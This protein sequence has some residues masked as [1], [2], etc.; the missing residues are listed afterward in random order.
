[1][2]K[3]DN[4][5]LANRSVGIISTALWCFNI[6]LVF[7]RQHT[8]TDRVISIEANVEVFEAREQFRDDG[9]VDGVV[10][11]LVDCWED[12]VVLFADGVHKC[13]VPGRVVRYTKL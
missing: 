2:N 8:S 11:A 9:A 13:H 12:V 1:M 10:G 5:H 6:E 3:K 7:S 4:L